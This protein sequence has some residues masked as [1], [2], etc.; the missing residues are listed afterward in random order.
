MTH[1]ILFLDD[2]ADAGRALTIEPDHEAYRVL[3]D[4]RSA[5]VGYRAHL[6]VASVVDLPEGQATPITVDE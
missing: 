6:G 3:A 1:L 2:A 4:G 5:G